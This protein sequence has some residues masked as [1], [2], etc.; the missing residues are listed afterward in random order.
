MRARSDRVGPGPRVQTEPS[1]DYPG[2]G[3]CALVLRAPLIGKPWLLVRRAALHKVCMR[4][5][6]PSISGSSRTER[7]AILTRVPCSNC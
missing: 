6:R 7:G 2:P 3:R 1:D 4:R 5:S